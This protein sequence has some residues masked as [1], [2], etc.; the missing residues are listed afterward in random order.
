MADLNDPNLYNELY[1]NAPNLDPDANGTNTSATPVV[2]NNSA[3]GQTLANAGLGVASLFPA[4]QNLLSGGQL[5]ASQSAYQNAV[6]AL[7]QSVPSQLANLIPTLQL[8]VVQGQMTPAQA[9]AAIQQQSQ[10]AGIKVDP[11]LMNAQMQSLTQLQ[12]IASSGGLTPQDKAQLQQINNQVNA[13]NAGRQLSVQQQAQQQGVGGSGFDLAARL[14]AAQQANNAASDA[15][16]NVAANAQQRALQAIQQSGQLGGQIQQ[17]Q[18]G[19]AA[20]K[21]AAQDAVNQFNTGLQ[22]QTNLTNTANAQQANA[23]NFT[24]ANQVAANNTAIKNQQALLP[25]NT[26]AEQNQQ[27][28]NWGA[29]AAKVDQTQGAQ[30]NTQA[31]TNKA[32]NTSTVNSLVQ[33]APGIV[34]AA[35]SLWGAFSDP[36]LKTDKKELS[37]QDVEDLMHKM[38]GY[39]YKYKDTVP[40][41]PKGMQT[42]IMSNDMKK[43]ALKDNVV[44]SDKGDVVVDNDNTNNAIFAALHNI[45]ERVKN[46]EG[47]K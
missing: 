3:N 5:S 22:Q 45:H 25:L 29:N 42:G 27:N 1:G 35:E 37:D 31:N 12:Q 38:T 14:G 40:N 46:M 2:N 34:N 30:L 21:A 47:N 13:Q 17:E 36:E 8:Q 28:L 7:N 10:L 4:V 16:T 20:Q 9:Q 43:T 44:A 19:E 15:G 39:K 11:S 18:F 6:N 26:A 32:N 41:A 23:L 33:N 24:N